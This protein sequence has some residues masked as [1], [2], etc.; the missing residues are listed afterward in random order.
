MEIQQFLGF[1]IFLFIFTAGFWI[2]IFLAS[3]IVP[4]WLTGNLIERWKDW[5]ASKK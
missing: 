2:M 1:L 5:R 3:F 4:Y